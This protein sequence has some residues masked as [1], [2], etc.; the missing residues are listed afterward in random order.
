M[1][2]FEAEVLLEDSVREVIE[3]MKEKHNE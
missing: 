3:Y 2:D 1:L